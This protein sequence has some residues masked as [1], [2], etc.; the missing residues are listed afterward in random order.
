MNPGVFG[1]PSPRT[2]KS[3]LR[4]GPST[5]GSFR[6]P[7]N[8]KDMTIILVGGGGGGGNNAAAAAAGGCGGSAGTTVIVNYP[9]RLRDEYIYYAIGAKGAGGAAGV[10][11][12]G[13]AGGATSLLALD[14]TVVV[15]AAGGIGGS[16]PTSTAQGLGVAGAGL[17]YHSSG[18][19]LFTGG[20][21]S[22]SA[23][24][25]A[26]SGI[27]DFYCP[28]TK[29]TGYAA[30]YYFGCIPIEIGGSGASG[31]HTSASVMG[32]DAWPGRWPANPGGG[33]GGG[34]AGGTNWY[35]GLGGGTS[36]STNIPGND[37][38]SSN[39]GAG[40]GGA[41]LYFDTTCKGGDG[42]QGCIVFEWT[43]E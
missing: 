31:G 13:A 27:A 8:A 40:G 10:A 5:Y 35:G 43:E 42:A 17:S 26:R 19:N 33:S 29:A 14:K 16:A 9:Q 3:V 30:P 41:G 11:A 37:A 32:V 38:N 15:T 36:E 25:N 4:V 24:A 2:R 23:S 1:F 21:G 39:Y 18:S 28:A 20:E 12:A 34:G 7:I 6:F 22:I